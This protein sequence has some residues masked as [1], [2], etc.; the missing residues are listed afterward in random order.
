M[1]LVRFTLKDAYDRIEVRFCALIRTSLAVAGAVQA[2]AVMP[3]TGLAAEPGIIRLGDSSIDFSAVDNG[4]Y[5]YSLQCQI[6]F[7]EGLRSL[8][9]AYAG[10]IGAEVTYSISA[11]NG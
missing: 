2:M 10:I 8:G 4:N 1:K 11:A 3:S 6:A 7:K 9:G 5:A